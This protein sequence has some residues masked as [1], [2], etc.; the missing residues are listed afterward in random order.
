MVECTAL[1]MR[2]TAKYRGFESHLLRHH[3]K[4]H[5]KQ[6][7]IDF[8][9]DLTHALFIYSL[10][11]NWVGTPSYLPYRLTLIPFTTPKQGGGHIELHIIDT[12]ASVDK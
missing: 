6:L 5:K 12:I 8:L 1:E 2:R 11:H 4:I 10:H 7:L 3:H 9:I